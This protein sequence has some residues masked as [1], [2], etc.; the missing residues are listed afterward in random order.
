MNAIDTNTIRMGGLAPTGVVV[1]GIV[2]LGGI[3]ATIAL[4][5]DESGWTNFWKSYVF[6]FMVITG[7]SLGGLFF[8]MLQHITRAGWSVTVRRLSE[9]L[10]S[11]LRWLWIA[12]VPIIILVWSGEGGVLY[13]W[14]DPTI[15]ANDPV[16]MKKAGYLDPTFWSI[17]AICFL[18]IWAALAQFFVGQSIRQDADGDLTRTRRMQAAAPVGILLYGI[19]QTFASVD[20]IMTLQPTWFSTMF[21]VYWFAVSLTGFFSCLILLACF[22]QSAGRL[23]GAISQEHYHDIGKL[24]FAFGVVFWAYIGYS[25]FMLIWYANIPIE[26][27]WFLP[28]QMGAWKWVSLLLIVGHFALPFLLLISRWPK[29]WKNALAAVAFWMV[30]MMIVD[31]YWLVMPTLPAEAAHDAETLMQLE[32]E[33]KSGSVAIGW[34]L[35]VANFTALIGMLGLLVAG[36]CAGLWRCSLVPSADPRLEESLAFEN[37]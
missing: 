22:L 24:L 12:F 31:V 35:T 2:G 34:N 37:L 23:K 8:V 33:V 18:V 6:A 27:G 14:A 32:E 26:T 21:G 4:G 9:G 25:Q 10:A 29:R 1:G 16:L 13:P 3:A 30:L 28:R 15:V 5:A 17:R 11:N 36:T 7:I 20:W 19:S